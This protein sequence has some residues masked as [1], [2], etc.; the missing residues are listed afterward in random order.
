MKGPLGTNNLS[1]EL[2]YLMKAKNFTGLVVS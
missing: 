2:K 1:I